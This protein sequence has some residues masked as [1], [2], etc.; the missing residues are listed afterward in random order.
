MYYAEYTHDTQLELA[1]GIANYEIKKRTSQKRFSIFKKEANQKKLI[2]K[3][4]FRD[5]FLF[6]NIARRAFSSVGKKYFPQKYAHLYSAML[7]FCEFLKDKGV[8]NEKVEL[9]KKESFE[10][11]YDLMLNREKKS[12]PST[13]MNEYLSSL[14][15]N[16]KI[17]CFRTKSN[18]N[19]CGWYDAKKQYIYLP[20]SSYFDTIL[21]YWKSDNTTVFPYKKSDFQKELIELNILIARKNGPN[22]SYFRPE[23]RMTISPAKD[24][25]QRKEAVL[26]IDVTKLSLSN[27]A[28]K[29]LK[30]MSTTSVSRRAPKKKTKKATATGDTLPIEE[31]ATSNDD[32]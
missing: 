12:T 16:G 23:H 21:D 17:I 8:G 1:E 15:E 32:L 20:Y 10:V 4:Q 5:K 31:N 7:T 13:F 3:R 29:L 25:T 26:K 30:D 11:I 9:L 18:K 2:C 19:T 22:S 6:N 14:I 28:K 24:K 27:D